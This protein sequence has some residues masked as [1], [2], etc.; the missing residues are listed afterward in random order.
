VGLEIERESFEDADYTAFSDRLRF[1]L[2]ALQRLFER[3]GFGTAPASIGAELELHLVDAAGRPS[4]INHAVVGQTVDPRVALE[5]DRFNLEINT[6]PERLAGTPFTR[7]AAQFDDSLREIG[8]AAR[9]HDARVVA[10]GILPTLLER[11]LERSALTDKRRY[12]ALAN[13]LRRLRP[14]PA[15]VRIV[16]DEE[17][18]V[19]ASDVSFEGANTS[20]QLHLQVEPQRFARLYNAAQ[21]ATGPVLAVACNSPIFL[22]KSLWDETRVALFRQSVDD[23]TDGGPDDW[24]PSRVS[25]GHGWV[26]NDAF[27]LFAESVAL[28]EPLLPICSSEDPNAVLANGGTPQLYSLRLHHGTV[29]R[30]NR[31]VYD[32]RNDGH[33]RIELRALPAGPSVRDMV[34]NMAL[35]VGLA[36]GLEPGLS[37]LLSGLTFGHARR[38]FYEAARFGMNAELIWPDERG[39]PRAVPATRLFERLL[40]IARSGLEQ[41]GVASPEAGGW[42]AV[43]EERVRRKVSGASW[44]K[45]L[46]KHLLRQRDDRHYATHALLERYQ[47]LSTSGALLSEWP[48]R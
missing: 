38:N 44:Q 33:L 36:A 16:G 37:E 31:A 10:T 35:A 14:S 24:R 32:P 5:V 6:H 1:E 45:A 26:R 43:V 2:G 40:P 27:E 46:F 3:P 34:A 9:C 20:L 22:G 25:F 42:L 12:R 8:S 28:H 4:P 17:L 48:E 41:L 13:G 15:T 7:L 47:E 11:D 19:T 21:A 18:E 29:W 30:W 23:R 39:T